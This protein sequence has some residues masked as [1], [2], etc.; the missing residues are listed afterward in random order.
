MTLEQIGAKAKERYP[1]KIDADDFTYPGS[2]VKELRR[3]AYIQCYKDWGA[4]QGEWIRVEDDL[5]EVDPEDIEYGWS[6]TV[7]T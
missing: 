4:V 6:I 3:N 7:D 2:A 1:D 5:P